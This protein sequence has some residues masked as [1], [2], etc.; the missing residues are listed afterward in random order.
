MDF[1]SFIP[2]FQGLAV[3]YDGIDTLFRLTVQSTHG[4]SK[5]TGAVTLRSQL[6]LKT[7][8]DCYVLH[9]QPPA[10]NKGVISATSSMQSFKHDPNIPR[11]KQLRALDQLRQRLLQLSRSLSSM[12]VDME[13]SDPVPGW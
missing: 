13:R 9:T 5:G 3:T 8:F 11:D 10:P 6:L 1:S 12:R 7:N 2:S 4:P